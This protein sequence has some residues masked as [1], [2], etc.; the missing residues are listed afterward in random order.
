MADTATRTPSTPLE[1]ADATHE[2]LC[3]SER[4]MDAT[5]EAERYGHKKTDKTEIRL[6]RKLDCYIMPVL[7]VMS[8]LWLIRWWTC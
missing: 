2:E 7:W 4:S 8:V 3:N 5:V 1:K 6:V